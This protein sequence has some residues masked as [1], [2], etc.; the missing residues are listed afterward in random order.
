MTWT[1]HTNPSSSHSYSSQAQP[2]TLAFTTNAARVP[3]LNIIKRIQVLLQPSEPSQAYYFTP[4]WQEREGEAEQDLRLGRF[5][6]F[7]TMDD[8]I[9][10]LDDPLEDE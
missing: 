2:F 4:L 5:Q 8:F 10:S 1:S 3:R 7:D 9:N 6:V